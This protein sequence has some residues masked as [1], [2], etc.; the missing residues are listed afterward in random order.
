M[1]ITCSTQKI[2][3]AAQILQRVLPTKAISSA[4]TGIHIKTN[5]DKIQ[6]QATNYE[7]SIEITIEAQVL[8]EGEIVIQGNYF[9]NLLRKLSS[10]TIQLS[11][12]DQENKIN[13]VS[14][15]YETDLIIMDAQEYPILDKIAVSN[16][17][18]IKDDML[19][20]CIKKTAFAC[21]KDESRPIFTGVL[22]NANEKELSFVATNTHIM[23]LKKQA[24]DT[25]NNNFSMVV[26]S[27]ILKEIERI[28]TGELPE[29]IIISWK[30]RQMAF[31][32]G[33]I[34]IE[35]RLIE[36]SFPDYKRVI[37]E[38]FSKQ[39]IF[40]KADLLGAVE[41]VSLLFKEE[42]Y[43]VLRLNIDDNKIVISS[44][45]PEIGK[46]KE[47]ID[48]E[49]KGG[50]IEIA[51]NSNYLNEIL[52]NIDSENAIINLNNSVSPACIKSENDESYLYIITPV[53]VAY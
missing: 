25:N 47:V 32:I 21:S 45:N 17:I 33:D 12:D 13:I 37:P 35:T 29:E 49:N 46:A 11:K 6:M 53:R 39:A 7:V 27:K 48:C 18:K 14:G 23:A 24:V 34:Y 20:D 22:V 10:E 9:A 19:K 8:E 15:V 36:G 3:K 31:K 5:K 50:Q 38:S 42:G 43:N 2:N 44:N 51:F 16:F 28:N 52:K 41:R 26:P 4:I 1:K 40:K 30:N